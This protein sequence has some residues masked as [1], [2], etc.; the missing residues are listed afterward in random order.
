MYNDTTADM[1]T[2]IR[3]GYMAK[4]ATVSMPHSKIKEA[5]ANVL[6]T[7]KYLKELT[8]EQQENK[9]NLV[10]TLLYN[11]RKPSVEKIVQVSKSSRRVY[12]KAQDLPFVLSG[13]GIAV[14]STSKGVM[15]AREARKRSLGGELICKIW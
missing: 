4:K 11:N 15:T 2:R 13:Y 10:L 7:Q 8:V 5:I 6:I 9:K 1:L 12:K 3:N 14:V